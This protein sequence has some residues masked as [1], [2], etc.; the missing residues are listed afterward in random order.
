M[1]Q[2]HPGIS[3]QIPT[4]NAFQ[5]VTALARRDRRLVTWHGFRGAQH[6]SQLPW[7]AWRRTTRQPS[8]AAAALTPIMAWVALELADEV[9][10]QLRNREWVHFWVNF[11]F[12]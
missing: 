5:C 3:Q 11:M 4:A 1:H 9:A 8:T 10:S 12:I 7:L 6:D 2:K